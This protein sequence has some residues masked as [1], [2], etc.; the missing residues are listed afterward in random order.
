MVKLIVLLKRKPGLS[1]EEFRHHWRHNHGPLIETTPEISR[2]VLAYEQHLPADSP[3]PIGREFD[4]VTVMTFADGQAF[5]DFVAE[6]A[7][8]DKVAPDEQR[9]LDLDGLVGII[10]DEGA[11]II[12]AR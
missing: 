11:S 6:P 5:A 10:V 9:F 3:I 7:Y 1:V 2:H 4:G 12:E 8:A